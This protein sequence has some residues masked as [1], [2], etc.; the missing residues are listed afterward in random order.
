MNTALSLSFLPAPRLWP[1]SEPA[2]P[3]TEAVS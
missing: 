3:P 1:E 2:I